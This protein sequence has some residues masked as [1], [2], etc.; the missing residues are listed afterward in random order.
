ME[1][2]HVAGR[3][4]CSKL[5]INP[6][7]CH[8]CGDNP[9]GEAETEARRER[10]ARHGAR[11]AAADRARRLARLGMVTGDVRGMDLL[12]AETLLIYDREIEAREREDAAQMAAAGA[13]GGVMG[14]MGGGRR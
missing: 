10:V 4:Q 2:E 6:A 9:D 8:G 14:G 12:E 1:A 11:I 3:L 13:V 7:A 5:R